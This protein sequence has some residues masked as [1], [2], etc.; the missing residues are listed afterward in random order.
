MTIR[1][2][3]PHILLLGD[4]GKPVPFAHVLFFQQGTDVPASVFNE[5]TQAVT[6]YIV[7]DDSGKFPSVTLAAAKYTLRAYVPNV[8]ES[9]SWPDDFRE[10][11]IWNLDGEDPA[12]E[13]PEIDP[14]IAGSKDAIRALDTTE[15]AVADLGGVRYVCLDNVHS[16][17]DDN[18]LVL[19]ST[20]DNTKMW[21]ADIEGDLLPVT[22]FGA[23]SSGVADSTAAI[24]AAISSSA[25]GQVAMADISIPSVVHFPNGIY[26]ISEDIQFATS[27]GSA[28]ACAVKF[29]RYARLANVSGNAVTLSFYA[30]NYRFDETSDFRMTGDIRF[31]F[32]AIGAPHYVD[33]TYTSGL[34]DTARV[35]AG[36]DVYASDLSHTPATIGDVTIRNLVVPFSGLG[37]EVQ[38]GSGKLT[39]E[40]I[41]FANGKL[42]LTDVAS[43][44]F[45]YIKSTIRTSQLQTPATDILK[46]VGKKLVIDTALELVTNTILRFDSVYVGGSGSLSYAY[47]SG[48]SRASFAV[49]NGNR[50]KLCAAKGSIA[51]HGI[52]FDEALPASC[53]DWTD[54]NGTD[55]FVFLQAH[56]YDADFGGASF[57]TSAGFGSSDCTIRNA[58]FAG[59]FTCSGEVR[60]SDCTFNT[61]DNQ[62]PCT[63]ASIEAT[64]CN[65]TNS[66]SGSVVVTGTADLNG[67]RISAPL[68]FG[69]GI[70]LLRCALHAKAYPNTSYGCTL[71]EIRDCLISI[72]DF[73]GETIAFDFTGSNPF[74]CIKDNFGYNGLKSTEYDMTLPSSIGAA[75]D[76]RVMFRKP[77]DNTPWLRDGWWE[78]YPYD[79]AHLATF[80]QARDG[81]SYFGFYDGNGASGKSAH[82]K[83]Y[84][85]GQAHT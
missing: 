27:G 24:K 10:Y 23:D 13:E 75:G 64:N 55:A 7:A 39:I 62:H 70:R 20:F 3:N 12:P 15:Y 57:S 29:D 8:A 17:A 78:G 74:V 34:I 11:E 26:T 45:V 82:I 33:G 28:T 40:N 21:L 46:I 49:F 2:H 16:W 44:N 41:D 58:N 77:S 79:G 32:S 22:L 38:N 69:V 51:I 4:D 76:A 48:G 68:S 56:G 18:G 25:L 53:F 65:F 35:G 14:F 66:G 81:V 43:G 19:V 50:G 36:A 72:A 37:I 31:D 30:P 63:F 60:A 71:V 47:A 73:I 59:G 1:P 42:D 80:T 54:A 5:D 9:P 85:S 67:C 52:D 6:N 84:A 61:A 83:L